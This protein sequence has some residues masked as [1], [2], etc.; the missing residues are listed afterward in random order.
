MKKF[1]FALVLIVSQTASLRADLS[2]IYPIGGEKLPSN[3]THPVIWTNSADL[4]VMAYIDW[5]DTN[6]SVILNDISLYSKVLAAGTNNFVFNQPSQY[7]TNNLYKVRLVGTN[8]TTTNT[9]TSDYFQITPAA[10]FT[11]QFTDTNL[12]VP[13]QTRT[14]TI[15]WSGFQ[16]SDNCLVIIECPPYHR[17]DYGFLVTN[18]T[19]TSG[20]GTQSLIVPYPSSLPS[21]Y[22]PASYSVVDG[23]HNVVLINERC[24]IVRSFNPVDVFT[25]GLRA[26]LVPNYTLFSIERGDSAVSASVILDATLATNNVAVTQ[27]AIVFTSYSTNWL[28]LKFTLKDGSQGL[29]TN[30]LSF[31]PSENENYTTLVTFPSS[32]TLTMGQTKELTLTCEV[33][34]DSEEGSF[35][36]T[37]DAP[38]V[39][40]G[41]TA[42]YVGGASIGK[43][44]Q[45]STGTYIDVVD[46]FQPK[47]YSYGLESSVASFAAMCR[48]QT[49]YVVQISTN[50]VN[51]SDLFTT[52]SSEPIMYLN[53]PVQDGNH[54]FRLKEN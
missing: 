9:V 39:Q 48:E 41:V 5:Y 40:F 25:E 30:T 17:A 16:S 21:A 19:L 22:P 18:L 12:W 6:G 49:T 46:V 37:T 42:T 26:S 45:S 52:N 3:G 54:F 35:L 38:S 28:S 29:S 14:N 2:L 51:W 10:V 8:V 43:A 27:I 15:T 11:S 32:L 7:P 31:R 44:V 13:G 33:L 53:F 24:G 20:S 47:F 34:S 50:L 4:G 36:W 1:L 23:M